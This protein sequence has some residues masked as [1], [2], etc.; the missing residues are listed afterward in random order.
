MGKPAAAIIANDTNYLHYIHPTLALILGAEEIK[1]IFVVKTNK[2]AS[3]LNSS[4]C[5]AYHL[6][7]A[8]CL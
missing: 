8:F 1:G 6:N 4:C 7:G 3:S 5:A 2:F